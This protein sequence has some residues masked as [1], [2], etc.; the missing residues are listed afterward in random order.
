MGARDR[1]RWLPAAGVA[2]GL[3]ALAGA[4]VVVRPL[5]AIGAAVR[6]L[7][8]GD[9]DAR[10]PAPPAVAPAALKEAAAA[11]NALAAHLERL[12][13]EQRDFIADVSHDIRGLA[14]GIALTAR[15]LQGLPPERRD[16]ARELLDALGGQTAR[17]AR[18]ADELLL[19]TSAEAAGRALQPR[20]VR[21]DQLVGAL[22]VEMRPRAEAQGLTLTCVPPAGP[23]E[24]VVDEALVTRAVANLLHNALAYTPAGG[25]IR[26]GVALAGDR[27]TIEVAD[28]G[29]GLTPGERE[30]L[31]ARRERGRAGRGRPGHGL[32]LAIVRRVADLH[33]GAIAV[34]AAPGRGTTFSLTLPAR[35]PAPPRP[36]PPAAAA[37]GAP[38]P[39]RAR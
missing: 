20:S 34:A 25:A 14:A 37:P 33:G 9:L 8:A 13:R 22:V 32:G 5:R 36:A 30:R 3:L 18:L 7:D 23:V 19:V 35:G 17:L 10:A 27:A 16:R 6:R 12:E 39:P 15:V 24:A 4:R 29:P 1:R 28:T 2:A 38:A 26:V 31:F 11:V 21:L